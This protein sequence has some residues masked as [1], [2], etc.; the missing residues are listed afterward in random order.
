MGLGV[1]GVDELPG[2]EA[3]RNLLGQLVSLGDGAL[4][5]L[6][7][8]GEHQLRA[9]GLHQLTAL[10]GHGLRHDDDDAVAPGGG[11]GGQAD[12]RLGDAVLYAAG[13]VE[14][15]QLGQDLSLQVVGLFNVGQLQQGGVAD[16]LIGGGIDSRH[17]VFSFL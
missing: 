11:H 10:H 15:F 14:V 4:H 12:H 17:D 8:L 3:A 9:V 7:A 5:A 16:E 6:G 2:Y 13:G 1:G